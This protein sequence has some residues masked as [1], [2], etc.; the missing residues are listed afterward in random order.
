MGFFF[1]AVLLTSDINNAIINICKI[2]DFFFWVFGSKYEK[3]K[4]EVFEGRLYE[5]FEP[6]TRS[7]SCLSS[8]IIFF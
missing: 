8:D 5:W 1:F 2:K 6:V 4:I 3:G 7:Q